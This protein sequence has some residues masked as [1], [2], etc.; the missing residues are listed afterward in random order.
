ME[1]V[2]CLGMPAKER[3]LRKSNG[4]PADA[5]GLVGNRHTIADNP[6]IQYAV[7]VVVIH[8]IHGVS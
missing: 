4:T 6:E 1:G 8:E 3:F 7:D 2:Y 5:V